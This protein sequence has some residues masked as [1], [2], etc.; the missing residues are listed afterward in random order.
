M[1]TQRWQSLVEQ[2][3]HESNVDAIFQTSKMGVLMS[4]RSC[5]ASGSLPMD[6]QII[7]NTI[8]LLT[9][10]IQNHN[11]DS[12]TRQQT[13]HLICDIATD[14]NLELT[15]QIPIDAVTSLVSLLKAYESIS[16]KFEVQEPIITLI[17]TLC[18]TDE[19]D[20]NKDAVT[21]YRQAIL[22]ETDSAKYVTQ[23]IHHLVSRL[24]S[25]ENFIDRYSMYNQLLISVLRSC[26][27]TLVCLIPRGSFLL[28]ETDWYVVY[29]ECILSALC[30]CAEI[31]DRSILGD[32]CECFSAIYILTFNNHTAGIICVKM[33][34]QLYNNGE[35]YMVKKAAKHA[36]MAI[37]VEFY[38]RQVGC[39]GRFPTDI[40][41][42]LIKYT[43]SIKL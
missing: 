38:I 14:Y 21:R 10:I 5:I 37:V 31:T 34:K 2:L 36:V 25:E 19:T 29:G 42:Q 24:L 12:F 35:Y 7:L 20:G 13:A 4:L 39:V 6:H 15:F 40:L 18:N 17:A 8:P 28:N 43:G 33:L 9:Q 23:I 22:Y 3:Q 27:Y 41:F 1:S 32:V 11:T 26:V 16:M 30:K